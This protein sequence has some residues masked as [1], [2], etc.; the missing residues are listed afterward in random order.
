MVAYF[1]AN[2]ESQSSSSVYYRNRWLLGGCW[3]GSREAGGKV[4]GRLVGRFTGGWW[5]SFMEG[6]VYKCGIALA[7]HKLF[8]MLDFVHKKLLETRVP[9]NY[10]FKLTFHI[11]I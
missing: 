8:S 9:N 4:H 7:F 2:F 3:E 11:K 5:E 1:H 6:L 10:F